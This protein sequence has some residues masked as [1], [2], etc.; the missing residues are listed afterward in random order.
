MTSG[1]DEEKKAEC[2]GVY[3]RKLRFK[4]RREVSFSKDEQKV[5]EEGLR[6]R[7]ERKHGCKG[8]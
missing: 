1:Q 3:M 6:V 7:I 2:A 4:G 5:R 8:R